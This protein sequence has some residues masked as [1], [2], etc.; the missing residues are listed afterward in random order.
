MTSTKVCGFS[1]LIE[2][3]LSALAVTTVGW[4]MLNSD[5]NVVSPRRVVW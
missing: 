5:R 3:V 1:S 4:S 2:I